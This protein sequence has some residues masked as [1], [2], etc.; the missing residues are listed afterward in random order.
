VYGVRPRAAA[1]DGASA[2]WRRNRGTLAASFLECASAHME[3][4]NRVT[5]VTFAA[6]IFGG[7]EPRRAM[8]LPRDGVET[9]ARWP[10]RF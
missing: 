1:G 7:R 5:L 8:A 6:L 2:R 4:V 9:A 3:C 10:L